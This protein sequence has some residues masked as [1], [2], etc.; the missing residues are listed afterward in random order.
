LG[1]VALLLLNKNIII[2]DLIN[3]ENGRIEIEKH[4][5]NIKNNILKI[6][7]TGMLEENIDKRFDS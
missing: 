3:L 7:L 5:S 6:L 2:K 4:L 1:I